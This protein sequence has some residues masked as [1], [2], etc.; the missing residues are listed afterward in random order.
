MSLTGYF[1]VEADDEE[2]DGGLRSRLQRALPTPSLSIAASDYP[3]V[4]SS[5]PMTRSAPLPSVAAPDLGAPSG[6]SGLSEYAPVSTGPNL[7]EDVYAGRVAPPTESEYAPVKPSLKRIALGG[8]LGGVAGIHNPQFGAEVGSEFIGA[9][10]AQREKNI[11]SDT[12]EYNA[13]LTQGRQASQDQLEQAKDQST[14]ALQHAQEGEANA[15][16]NAINNPQPTPKADNWQMV[17][18]TNWEIDTATGETREA[19]GVPANRTA[20]PET[21]EMGDST[22]QWDGSKWNKIGPAKKS[23]TEAGTWSLQEDKDGKPILMN[24]KTGETKPANGIQKSG[25]KAKADE[26]TQK[27]LEPLDSDEQFADD[28]LNNGVFTG[29]KDEALQEKYF[30]LAKPSTGFRMSQ[31]QIDMLQNS[32]N[33]MGSAEAHL[34]H[35]EN[36]TWFS[37]DQRRQIVSAMHDLAEAKRKTIQ[38]GSQNQTGNA[39]KG[40]EVGTTRIIN[41]QPAYWDGNGWLPGK[42]PNK[43]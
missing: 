9:P 10:A 29:P 11:A 38:G 40:P 28:Y 22:Y 35:M 14:E 34:R 4:D 19:K 33:W 15:R 25:T 39:P 2:Q 12:K 1:P 18:D 31:P 13:A 17:P 42:P 16:T 3:P 6:D 21:L 32:R 26:A 43:K 7:A 23:D 5:A 36:G 41:G 20:K 24:S 37:N 30:D 8:L 27:E